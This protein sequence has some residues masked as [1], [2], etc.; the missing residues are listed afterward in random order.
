[1][2]ILCKWYVSYVHLLYVRYAVVIA[3]HLLLQKS[4]GGILISGFIS[5]MSFYILDLQQINTSYHMRN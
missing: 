4:C 2:P 3:N 1:M 5:H